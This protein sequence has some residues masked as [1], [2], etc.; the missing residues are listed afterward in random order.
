MGTPTRFTANEILADAYADIGVL[1]AGETMTADMAQ[2]GLRR[3][4]RMI[5]QMATQELTFPF[6]ARQVFPITALKNTY[7][8]GPGG[9]LDTQR[10][11]TIDG[12][13]LLLT[14]T[15]ASAAITGVSTTTRTFTV[16]G[17]QT[18]AFLSGSDC[19]VTGSTGNDGSYTVVSAV[20]ASSTTIT[21]DEVVPSSVA[22]GTIEVLADDTST[23]EI[24]VGLL[25]DNAYQ[26][27][28]IKGMPNTLFTQAYYNA[29]YAG[30]L[31][32]LW[33]WPKPTQA[34]NAIVLYVAQQI[35]QFADLVTAYD[36]PPGYADLFEYGVALRLAPA[37]GQA[38]AD[39]IGPLRQQFATAVALVKRSNLKPNDMPID[40]ALVNGAGSIYN[41]LTGNG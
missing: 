21:V 7:T 34:T 23:V 39:I 28:Q 38:N 17:D 1:G 6:L 26:A 4:N 18:G 27:I 14:P 31:G 22:D 33:L 15:I 2:Q 36:F 29:T 41:I 32:T 10:P 30:G 24:P 12:C 16:A 37:F 3:L 13:G 9:D 20:Y 25:T 35:A 11:M 5:S 8:I 40:A 19:I